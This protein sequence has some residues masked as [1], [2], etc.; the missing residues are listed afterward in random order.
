[1]KIAN[2]PMVKTSVLEAMSPEQRAEHIKKCSQYCKELGNEYEH[3]F[4]AFQKFIGYREK[5]LEEDEKKRR[6][7]I[8]ISG[9]DNIPND[10][11]IL[12]TN[13][14]NAYDAYTIARVLYEKGVP[15]SIMAAQDGINIVSRILL[16]L[17]GSTMVDRTS[18]ISSNN[19][20]LEFSAKAMKGFA[21]VILPEGTWNCHPVL[22][23]LNLWPGVIKAAMISG[24]PIVPM[25]MEYIEVPELIES[26]KELYSRCVIK[27]G[28]PFYIA[29]TDDIEDRLD[30]LK[31]IMIKMREEIQKEHYGKVI[32]NLDEV[33]PRLYVNHMWFR[34]YGTS[35]KYNNPNEL[36]RLFL[37]RGEKAVNMFYMNE[38]G[39]LVDGTIPKEL[40]L[41]P[42]FPR[43]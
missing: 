9:L 35:I 17:A 11:C 13:H 37:K 29:P 36:L 33:N 43:P 27:I 18:S 19:A 2:G 25:I 30:E 40:I 10:G 6:Y 1:M 15:F 28:Q 23:M 34:A 5:K 3:Q 39:K 20:L 38:N 7:I 42:N 4:L 32:N 41:T 26:E 8:E 12:A 21:S 31:E 22:K 14:T 16:E 24:K